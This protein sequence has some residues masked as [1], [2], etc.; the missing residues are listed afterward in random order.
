MTGRLLS[1]QRA[2]GRVVLAVVATLLASLL[3]PL[4]VVAAQGGYDYDCTDFDNRRDAQAFYE[5][6][7]GLDYDPYNLDDDKD[8]T[9]CEEWEKTYEPSRAEAERIT[10]RDGIDRDCADFSSSD[11]AQRYFDEDGGS[12]AA[13]VDHLDPNHN[14]IACEEGEPG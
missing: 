5:A 10:G 13:D 1:D 9:A 4:G 6:S 3:F 7:G 14:G 8:G 2:P 12:A 11:E